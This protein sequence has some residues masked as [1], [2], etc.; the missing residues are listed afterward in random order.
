MTRQSTHP[1]KRA[2]YLFI[3]LGRMKGWV[4]L[5]DWPVADGLPTLWSPVGCRGAQDRVSSPAK[6]RRSANCA[7]QPTDCLR[8]RYVLIPK[9][10]DDVKITVVYRRC[11]AWHRHVLTVITIVNIP[12]SVRTVSY[13]RLV[14]YTLHV[15]QQDQPAA[16]TVAIPNHH[17]SVSEINNVVNK[18]ENK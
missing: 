9:H 10:I 4:G 15:I 12:T 18:L 17:S 3:D 13:G 16:R 8:C 11:A 14:A 5:I 7:T 6:D 2:C 1:I